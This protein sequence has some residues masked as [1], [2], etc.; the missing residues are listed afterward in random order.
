MLAPPRRTPR[1]RTRR[2]RAALRLARPRLARPRL[3]RPR[4]ARPRLAP[5]PAAR[6]ARPPQEQ[7]LPRAPLRRRPDRRPAPGAG[8]PGHPDRDLGRGHRRPGPLGRERPAAAPRLPAP[9]RGR[10]RPAQRGRPAA[11]KAGRAGRGLPARRRGGVPH[12]APPPPRVPRLTRGARCRPRRCRPNLGQPSQRQP[13]QYRPSQ[14]RPSQCQTSC[15]GPASTGLRPVPVPGRGP[16]RGGPALRVP[17]PVRAA[18]TGPDL[19]GRNSLGMLPAATAQRLADVIRQ[20]WGTGLIRSWGH[21]MDLPGQVGDLLGE[22]LLGA[23]PGQVT[24]CD[25]TTVNLYKLAWAALDARPGR[26]VLVTDDD[27]FPTDRYVLAGRGPVRRPAAPDPHRPG[28]GD[29]AGRRPR[30]HR[31]GHRAG[32]PL[33]RGLPERGAGRHGRDHP[34]RARGGGAGALGPVPLRRLGPGGPGRVRRRP[35][36]RLYLQVPERRSR[37]A[38]VPVRPP[39]DP[40][41]ADPAHPGL[42]RPAGPVHDGAPLRARARD[43][44]VSTGTPNV[45]G[46]VAVQE[47][48]RL[49]AEAGVQALRDKGIQLTSY[50]IE[51]ADAWLTPLGCELASPRDPARRGSHVTLH[52]LEAGRISQALIRAGVIGDFRTPD[53]LRLGPAR[54]PPGSPTSGTRWAPSARSSRRAPGPT[55]H[56]PWSHRLRVGERPARQG[57]REKSSRE[58]RPG[59]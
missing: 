38:G 37:R 45:P 16:G 44:P 21:W 43:R 30:R 56:R 27:N 22:H 36:G 47:G 40:G 32:L 25:S 28:Q 58:S 4:L 51:L 17:G 49:L 7:R 29:R 24:V 2:P 11:A 1:P 57:V 23:G 12:R 48:T 5:R 35:G 6:R 50:L 19:P 14:Q 10:P 31:A 41:P 42:V 13:N 52:H 55:F 18:R 34:A 33:A 15:V 54:S 26:P 9:G 59:T 53:R 39:R 46:T 8:Q 20:D 3:A